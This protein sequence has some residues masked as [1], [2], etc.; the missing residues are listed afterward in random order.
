ML[1]RLHAGAE[2]IPDKYS[3]YSFF[4]RIEYRIGGR[5]GESYSLYEGATGQRV[6]HNFWSRY[7]NEKVEI[8]D[9]L[10]RGSFNQGQC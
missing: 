7:T 1:F 9:L 3:N 4:D 8:T 2:Y 5:Y 10:L 6:R